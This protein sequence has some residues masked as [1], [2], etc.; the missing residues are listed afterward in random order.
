MRN[1]LISSFVLCLSPIVSLADQTVILDRPGLPN[2]GFNTI[3][4]EP[5]F[6]P[7]I[8]NASVGEQIHFVSQFS[9]ISTTP[10]R[11]PPRLSLLIYE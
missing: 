7:K 11:P 5:V 1:F 10:V 9:D 2:V 3:I 6:N 4:F 8:V